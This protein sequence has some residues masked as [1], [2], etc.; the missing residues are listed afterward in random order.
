MYKGLW[1]EAV[2]VARETL[3][4][5]FEISEWQVT[6][7]ASAWAAFA[8]IKLGRLED[9]RRFLE[10]A[11]AGIEQRV[12]L[13][14]PRAYLEMVVAQLRLTQGESEKAL[15]AART[16]LELAERG[17]YLLEQ[18]AAHRTL[19]QVYAIGGNR[20]EAEAAFRRSLEIL[21][22]IQSRPELAQTLLAYGRFKLDEDADEGNRLLHRALE[23][24]Q[25][26]DAT[27]WV[28]ETRTA[29]DT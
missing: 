13:D 8:C 20:S 25:D 27:G 22:D 3:P 24:F 2:G 17:G 5:A 28:E 7:F 16:A 29:L 26:M 10:K 12:G 21:G 9:A 14:F 11:S 1:E 6:L 4:V 18:G 15:M 19:G 23:L